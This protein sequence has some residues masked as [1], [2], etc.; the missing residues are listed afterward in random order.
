ME[1][2]YKRKI[3][4]DAVNIHE[5][6]IQFEVDYDDNYLGLRDYADKYGDS[7]I[8]LD[9]H[10]EIFTDQFII[11]DAINRLDCSE[12]QYE[13]NLYDPYFLPEIKQ[14][15]RFLKKWRVK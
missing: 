10:P 7:H 4:K 11:D 15:K 13:Y 2:K 14:L 1:Y 3:V 6:C 12:N 8:A 5:M 9:K